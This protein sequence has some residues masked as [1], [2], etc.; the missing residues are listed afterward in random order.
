MD[1]RIRSKKITGCV[2]PLALATSPWDRPDEIAFE[3]SWSASGIASG[4]YL[5]LFETFQS[6]KKTSSTLRKFAVIR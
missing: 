2:I 4:A 5:A 6:G 1:R 3:K